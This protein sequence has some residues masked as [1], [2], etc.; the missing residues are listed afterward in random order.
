MRASEAILQSQVESNLVFSAWSQFIGPEMNKHVE[1]CERIKLDFTSMLLP[2]R[3]DLCPTVE[4]WAFF[5]CVSLIPF[6][7][8]GMIG[9]ICIPFFLLILQ[10]E[11]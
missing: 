11:P 6:K 1:T 8:L 5:I 9:K 3:R 7:K 4:N 10:F 2:P